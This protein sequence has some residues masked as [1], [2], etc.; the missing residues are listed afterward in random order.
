V[1]WRQPPRRASR[2]R[3]TRRLP[4]V[5][6]GPIDAAEQTQSATDLFFIVAGANIV[7]TTLVT[8]AA[9]AGRLAAGRALGLIALGAV[10]GTLLVAALVPVGSRLAVPSIIAARAALGRQGAGLLALG[11][12]VTN[13]AWIAVNNVIA[14]SVCAAA[15]PGGPST[16]TFAVILGLL[17]TA[18]VAAGPRAVSRA[19]RLA[20]PLMLLVG[21]LMTW[22]A[23][24]L[25]AMPPV[26][27]PPPAGFLPL[28]TG[29]DIVIAYQVSWLFLFADYPRFT[30]SPGKAQ[31]A[32][33]LGLALTSAWFMSL[34][35]LAARAAGSTDPGAM[36]TALGLMGPGALLLALATIAS[37]F[38]NIYM[39]A[40]AWKSL[41]P[42]AR[43]SA[44]V[45]TIGGIGAALS[46]LDQGWL[47]RYGAFMAI[48]GGLFVPVAGILFARF[49]LLRRP[50]AVEVLYSETSGGSGYDRPAL[51]AW[52]VAAAVYLLFAFALTAAPIGGTLPCLATAVVC[53][54]LLTRAEA[55]RRLAG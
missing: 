19:D 52:A 49:F 9:L 42:G 8:G 25:P 17:A 23:F 7:A 30:R 10:A 55:Q 1:A 47:S 34:G 3:A 41:F 31:A 26:L 12:Y 33:F 51:A 15:M 50:V 27:Q 14:A 46:L 29:L 24:R 38:V 39:S 20:V 40:L 11:V 4:A 13:F 45:W 54:L 44:S 35:F 32:V 36:M 37:N 6:V 2:P 5:D 43:D 53:Y 18:V 22:A 28:V 16:R 21:V 48:I